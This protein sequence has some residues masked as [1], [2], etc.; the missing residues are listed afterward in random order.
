MSFSRNIARLSFLIIFLSAI[1]YQLHAFGQQ[2]TPP[3][4]RPRRQLSIPAQQQPEISAADVIRVNTTLVTVPVSVID[5]QGRYL[6]DLHQSQFHVYENG[7]EQQIAYFASVDK[8]FTV[9]LLLDISD[10]TEAQLKL[11]Q[12]AAIA[13][14]ERLRPD[15]QV[16]VI[17][18]DSRV[19]LLAQPPMNRDALRAAIRALQSGHGT[20]LYAVVEE[21][22]KELAHSISGRKAIV[23]LTDGI[24]TTTPETMSTFK[25]SVERAEESDVIVY[26]VQV[27]APSDLNPS[28][29]E[30]QLRLRFPDAPTA[31]ALAGVNM[32]ARD[33][34][35]QLAEKTG[36]Q[37]YV[38][39]E[40][41]RLGQ[42]FAR[43]A[44]ELRRQYSL[45]YYPKT[46][47]QAGE[48]REIKVTVDEP[49]VTV[50]ARPNYVT[51]DKPLG[52]TS[53]KP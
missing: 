45:G 17:A 39:T 20:S 42:S 41:G 14:I 18:F 49:K 27:N 38:A 7:V 31:R 46:K 21:T 44:D 2:A 5:R 3:E 33:Y 4:S 9:A 35:H 16:I 24:D 28:N 8:P 11:I 26:P 23:L 50:R 25:S 34:L 13:F 6:A 51:N 43:V 53:G 52:D 37:F 30:T 48:M 19:R 10:S 15:D 47:P 29:L 32:R 40:L 12:E 1:G 36:G 22:I